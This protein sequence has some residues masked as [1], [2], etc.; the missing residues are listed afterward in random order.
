MEE[1]IIQEAEYEELQTP[2]I[3]YMVCIYPVVTEYN[4][5]T[6]KYD[7]IGRQW[8]VWSTHWDLA[9]ITKEYHYARKETAEGELVKLIKVV[10][11]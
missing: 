4:P 9:Q 1:P 3:I 10:I 2:G 8:R 5:R 11:K 6:G 7:E